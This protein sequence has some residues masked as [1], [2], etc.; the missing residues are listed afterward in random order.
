MIS[1]SSLGARGRER[2]EKK[3]SSEAE[4]NASS[5]RRAMQILTIAYEGVLFLDASTEAGDSTCPLKRVVLEQSLSGSRHNLSVGQ[6]D[7]TAKWSVPPPPRPVLCFG[8]DPS[9]RA[10]R[11]E[12]LA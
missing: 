2:P 10:E 8:S 5:L 1:S 6:V 4:I 7:M 12:M 9:N 3:W 11:A